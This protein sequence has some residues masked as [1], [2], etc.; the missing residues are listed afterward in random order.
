MRL[1]PVRLHLD[2]IAR[3][4]RTARA[5]DLATDFDGTLSPIVESPGRAAIDPHARAALERLLSA[6]R[7][8][9]A[10]VSGRPLADLRR[11]VPLRGIAMAGN[12][13][14]EPSRTLAGPRRVRTATLPAGLHETLVAWAGRFPRAW[15]ERKGHVLAAHFGLLGA[16]DRTRFV[17]GVRRRV[18]PLAPHV[19][20]T[21]GGRSIELAPAGSADKGTVLRRWHGN[22]AAGTLLL[23]L[24]DDANDLPALAYA[25]RCGGVA[26]AVG[27]PLAGA[28]YQLADPREAAAFL[29]WLAQVW[30]AFGAAAAGGHGA[31]DSQRRRRG[32]PR[33][34]PE[35]R[36]IGPQ[37]RAARILR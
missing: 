28:H 10:V 35:S 32:A 22:R 9:V 19:Q 27:R 1:P 2:A 4:L 12:S 23:Y 6:P 16:R 17:A 14:I 7:A 36:E 34:V 11:L 20:V 3:R 37:T 26:I 31:A 25:R 13:G 29:A 8:R 18:T 15:I 5:L 24:G 21:R 30:T 33:V